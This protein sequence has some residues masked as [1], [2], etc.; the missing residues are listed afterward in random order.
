[1]AYVRQVASGLWQVSVRRKGHPAQSKTFDTKTDADEWGRGVETDIKR[2]VFQSTTEAERMTLAELIK[3]FKKE[4]APNHYRVREDKK[5]AWRFQC[6]RIE[7]SMGAFSLAAIDRKLVAKFRD[8]RLAG[9]ATREAVKESTVRKE[10]YLLSKILDYAQGECDIQL[11]RGNPVDKIRKPSEGKSRD[12][13]LTAEEWTRLTAEVEASR[14][15][16]LLAAWQLAVETAMRQGELLSVPWKD[17]DLKRKLILL[18]DT[19]KIKNEE[20]R[21]VPLSSKA[22]AALESL[23]RTLKGPVFPVERMTLYHAFMYACQRA[24][25]EDFTW[26]DLR[27]EALSRIAERGGFNIIEIAAISGHKTLQM[28]KRYTHLDAEKLAEKLG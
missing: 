1:M 7:E 19:D 21:A 20:R 9:T 23:P 13:R 25:I 8:D 16:W 26:H 12:R 18:R 4:F 11:P 6:D 15:P 17:V 10:I 22:I 24:K 2:G 28:L 14:N 27:H 3:K 5:E